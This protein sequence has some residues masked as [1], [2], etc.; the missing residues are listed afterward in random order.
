MSRQVFSTRFTWEVVPGN[1]SAGGRWERRERSQGKVPSG[2]SWPRTLGLISD[3]SDLLH[4]WPGRLRSPEETLTFSH[5]SGS[6]K[7][8]IKVSVWLTSSEV[9][10][11]GLLDA[12]FFLGPHPVFSLSAH[13]PGISSPFYKDLVQIGLGP[14]CMETFEEGMARHS[15]ILAWRLLCL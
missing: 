14:S 7:F 8:K 12:T 6:W 15:S 2:A 4:A 10:L 5:S 1:T 11:V 9:S 3:A 13:I